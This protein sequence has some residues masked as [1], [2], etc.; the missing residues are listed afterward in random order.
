MDYGEAKDVQTDS[1]GF[2]LVE[3]QL[4]ET[5]SDALA[6]SE[7]ACSK[8]VPGSSRGIDDEEPT[9][10][11]RSVLA[12]ARNLQDLVGSVVKALEKSE[13]AT[14]DLQDQL[15]K[16]KQDKRAS[17]EDLESKVEAAPSIPMAPSSGVVNC[18]KN[19]CVIS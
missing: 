9:V 8:V 19:H 17:V 12:K 7:S 3:R 16:A 15:A 6:A 4:L 1:D 13:A 18:L 2:E 14:E 11:G 10:S 5:I